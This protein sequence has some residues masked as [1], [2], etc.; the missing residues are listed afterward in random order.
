MPFLRNRKIGIAKMILAMAQ[1][2]ALSANKCERWNMPAERRFE[3][4][5]D[6]TETVT[7][8]SP[9][10]PPIDI[11]GLMLALGALSKRALV[12]LDN[13]FFLITIGSA[14]YLWLS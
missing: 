14:F 4:I 7:E 2:W 3:L 6:E 9:K 13:L 5:Q 8:A 1:P 12:A 10:R 11:Q